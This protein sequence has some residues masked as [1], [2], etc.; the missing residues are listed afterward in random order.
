MTREAKK[1]LLNNPDGEL[2]LHV[3]PQYKDEKC[4]NYLRD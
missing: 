3:E 1:R 2:H 4:E